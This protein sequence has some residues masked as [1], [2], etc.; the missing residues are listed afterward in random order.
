M[1]TEDEVLK[2]IAG[3]VEKTKKYKEQ[4]VNQGQTIID[5]ERLL[6]PADL[7]PLL[8]FAKPLFQQPPG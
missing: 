7:L 3:I 5:L 6:D 8:P 2:R 4:T 1:L